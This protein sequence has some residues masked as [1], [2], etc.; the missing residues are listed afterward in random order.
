MPRSPKQENKMFKGTRR[1]HR[2]KPAKE[3][4]NLIINQ[5]CGNYTDNCT[6]VTHL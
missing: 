5:A 6:L 4:I 1:G 3:L 2:V